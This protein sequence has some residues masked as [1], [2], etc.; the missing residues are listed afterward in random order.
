MGGTGGNIRSMGQRMPNWPTGDATEATSRQTV[1]FVRGGKEGEERDSM[2]VKACW[3]HSAGKQNMLP[4]RLCCWSIRRLATLVLRSTLPV[5]SPT[6]TSAPDQRPGRTNWC[7]MFCVTL[8]GMTQREVRQLDAGLAGGQHWYSVQLPWFACKKCA[9]SGF[10][11]GSSS[12][13]RWAGPV[14]A[15]SL[16]VAASPPSPVASWLG[17]RRQ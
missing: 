15:A 10:P 1:Y 2:C 8:V 12:S 6:P 5:G 3:A 9:C 4:L 16:A 13:Q 11:A 7:C 17:L 14:T